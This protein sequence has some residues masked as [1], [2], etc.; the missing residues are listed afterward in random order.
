MKTLSSKFSV[1]SSPHRSRAAVSAFFFLSGLCFASWASRIPDI[2]LRLHL[3]AGRLGQLLLAVPAGSLASLPLAGTLVHRW[4]SRRTTLLAGILYAVF[5]VLLGA[6][7]SFW[8]LAGALALFGAAGNVFNIAMNTQALGVQAQFGRPIIGSFHG[9][10]SLAGFLG[11]ALGTMLIK[12]HQPPL[13]HFLLVLGLSLAL[14]ALAWPGTLRQDVGGERPGGLS[15]RRP[16]PYL[17]RV[18]LLAFC[19]MLSE[20]AMFDWAGVYFQ[21]VVRPGPALVTVG[22]VACL[23]TMAAGRFA[24]DYLT[25]HLGPVRLLRLSSGLVV[26]GLALAVSFPSLVPATAG[27]LLV[28]FGIAAVVPLAYAAAGR[29]TSVSPGVALALVSSIGFLGFLLGP[30]LVGLLGQHF[31]LRVALGAV[32]VVASGV[33]ALARFGR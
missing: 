33:G 28:G 7:D 1:P 5:L 24:S 25:R 27:F 22:Y 20:G 31:G 16:D 14:A 4:G 17:L 23:G 30:P 3:D 18:G 26:S 9:L 21:R 11:G 10:W 29:A 19:G 15:L 32:A 6:A 8:A 13:T 2:S 12:R